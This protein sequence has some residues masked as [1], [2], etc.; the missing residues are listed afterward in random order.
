MSRKPLRR[1]ACNCCATHRVGL[2]HRENLAM[3]SVRK[4]T[5]TENDRV[6]TPVSTYFGELVR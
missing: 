2:L 5:Y 6:F 3:V 4:T 1:D